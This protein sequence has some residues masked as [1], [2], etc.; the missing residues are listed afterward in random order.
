MYIAICEQAKITICYL[1]INSWAFC[2]YRLLCVLISIEQC[3]MLIV[4][5]ENGEHSPAAACMMFIHVHVSRV[6]ITAVIHIACRFISGISL[7]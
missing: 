5:C 2:S 1:S 4:S 7:W 3:H 6:V